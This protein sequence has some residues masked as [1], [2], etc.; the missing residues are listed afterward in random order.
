MITFEI[1]IDLFYYSPNKTYK[2]P[3]H[4]NQPEAKNYNTD[5]YRLS[6]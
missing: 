4:N 5:V 3:K 1:E 2:F 6:A